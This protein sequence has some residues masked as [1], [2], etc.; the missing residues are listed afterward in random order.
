M[1]NA[2]DCVYKLARQK[3]CTELEENLW[4]NQKMFLPNKVVYGLRER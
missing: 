2:Q 3:Q 1:V 4:T